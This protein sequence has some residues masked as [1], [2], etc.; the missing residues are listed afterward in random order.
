MAAAST[1]SP[2]VPDMRPIAIMACSISR[3]RRDE[4]LYEGSRDR[5][6]DGDAEAVYRV[7][8]RASEVH[9]VGED[10]DGQVNRRVDPERGAGESSVPVRVLAEIA[11]DHR[12][13]RRAEREPDAAAE[14]ALLHVLGPGQAREL[15]ADDR[16]VAVHPRDPRD[17]VGGAE[18]PGVT[19]DA[20]HG[21]RVLVVDLAAQALLAPGLVLL[22]S[23]GSVPRTRPEVAGRR[24]DR[25]EHML[26][27]QIGVRP[28]RDPRERLGEHD[29]AEV[30]VL[31]GAR[32]LRQRLLRRTPDRLVRILGV[33]P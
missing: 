14:V 15:V 13:L 26:A 10:D 31:E 21:E 9:A 23:H 17:V 30:A 32:V 4:E 6:M 20:A 29:V 16:A 5:F 18:E 19:G 2:D 1:P 22:G 12:I 33:A 11:A 8:V 27:H 25:A 7:V 3:R 24:L 28:L